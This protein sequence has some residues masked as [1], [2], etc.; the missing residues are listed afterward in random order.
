MGTPTQRILDLAG[1][2]L[3][4]GVAV[5]KK[6]K[7]LS[8]GERARLCLAGLLLGGFNILVLDEPG[9]HLDVETVEAL[10]QALCSYAGTV[11][12]TSHDRTF[13]S[14]VATN[15]IEVASGRVVH[16]PGS[17]DRYVEK[18]EREVDDAEGLRA[19]QHKTGPSHGARQ[20]N[21]AQDARKR[22]KAIASLE[23]T[24]A[25]LDA[26]RQKKRSLMAKVT[27][28]KE[29]MQLHSDLETVEKD[30]AAAEDQWLALQEEA[31][32]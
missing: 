12:F 8:G 16:Y 28:P 5:E 9:N 13:V 20:S 24:V 23:K 25:R 21:S 18:I 26:E 17:Y 2:M 19:P 6:I 15:V 3:F 22:R 10:G 1:A 30:L 7:V 29:A 14:A 4:Q 31:A 32:D 27:D 11:I